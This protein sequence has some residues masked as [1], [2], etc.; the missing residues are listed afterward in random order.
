[1]SL[2]ILDICFAFLILLL[3]VY[4]VQT[5][6]GY[7]YLF[8]N[9]PGPGYFPFWTGVLL[10]AFSVVNIFR[11]FLINEFSGKKIG[12]S[13]LIQVILLLF[14][15]VA[16][17]YLSTRFGMMLST[18]IFILLTGYILNYQL[19]PVKFFAKIIIIAI[20]TTLIITFIFRNL[21][22]VPIL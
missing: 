8:R 12:G 15:V 1:M 6:L 22:S 19:W 10:I 11:C 14:S 20:A 5:S 18:F 16:F 3:G 17:I 2:K 9:V 7:G 13:E 4:I 21:L